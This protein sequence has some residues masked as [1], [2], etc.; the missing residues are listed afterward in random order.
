V[1][2]I[3]VG[4]L[5]PRKRVADLVAA[6]PRVLARVAEPSRVRFVVVGDGPER[7]RL[8]RQAQQLGVAGRIDFVGFQDHDA[9]KRLLAEAHIFASPVHGE[10]FG[11]AILEARAAGLPVVAMDRGGVDEIVSNGRH[12]FLAPSRDAF[13]DAL[14]RLVD[15]EPL[16]AEMS[17]AAVAGLEPYGWDAVARRHEEIYQRAIA[18][19]G[20]QPRKSR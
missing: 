9:V 18:A 4:R 10:A 14:V 7:P 12:G 17:E 2:I 13:V 19:R 15:D 8:E 3:N 16:R 11:T 1:R 20:G 6:V 5:K